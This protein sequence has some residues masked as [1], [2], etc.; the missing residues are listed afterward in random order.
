MELVADAVGVAGVRSPLLRPTSFVAPSAQVTVVASDPG[1]A[2]VALAL[3][4]AGRIPLSTGRVLLDGG[5]D[6][7]ARTRHVAL[8]DVPEVSAPEEGLAL[9]HVVAEELAFAGRPSGPEAVAR[10]LADH[11]ILVPARARFEDLEPADRVRVLVHAAAERTSTRV[12]VVT[13]PDRR[14]GDPRVW[15]P[16][17]TGLAA[18]GLTV[19][20]V[21]THA[22]IR[23][24]ELP[25]GAE[26]GAAA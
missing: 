2:Q 18:Q 10:F 11:G 19:I 7:S 3:A 13:G 23:Q 12:L 16:V 24:L 26:L 22:T 25:D 4:L 9:H 1:Y 6:E 5:D 14:G 8:V 17:L 20:A 21:L 15:W